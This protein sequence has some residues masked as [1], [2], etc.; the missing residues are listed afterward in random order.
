GEP[1]ALDERVGDRLAAVPLELG[2]V[3]EELEL[4]GP[5]GHEQV[6][7][8]PGPGGEMTRPGRQRIDAPR[9]W[10]TRRGRAGC[11]GAPIG[12]SGGR[13]TLIEQRGQGHRPEPHGAVGEKVAPSPVSQ[14]LGP[15]PPCVE[16]PGHD[17]SIPIRT[18]LSRRWM[19]WRT[20]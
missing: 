2:L 13:P 15:G 18:G 19:A 17:S 3:I 14:R 1:P 11:R 9:P 20:V 10:L 16:I 6:D 8:A 4:A 5:A 7:H 12:P